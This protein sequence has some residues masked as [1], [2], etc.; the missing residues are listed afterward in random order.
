[1]NG[2]E[3]LSGDSRG[4]NGQ[5]IDLTTVHFARPQIRW[6]DVSVLGETWHVRNSEKCFWEHP[7]VDILNRLAAGPA[8]AGRGFGDCAPV[9]Q[10]HLG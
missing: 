5:P 1:M 2:G 3:G 4:P 6:R 9:V 8:R 7:E 10:V